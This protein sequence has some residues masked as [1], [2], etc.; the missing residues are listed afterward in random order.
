ML[1]NS[2]T[3]KYFKPTP[4]WQL[5]KYKFCI[6]GLRVVQNICMVFCDFKGRHALRYTWSAGDWSSWVIYRQN[7][8]TGSP[9][10]RAESSDHKVICFF[11]A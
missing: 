7:Q 3:I 4:T 8:P 9:V 10:G 6:L 5:F 2:K 11:R 1:Q